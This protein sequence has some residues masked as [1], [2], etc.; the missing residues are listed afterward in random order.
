MSRAIL[1]ALLL[2]AALGATPSHAAKDPSP[3][4][5]RKLGMAYY[6]GEGVPTDYAKA[7]KHLARAVDLGDKEA[8]L[9]LGKM[10]EY[11]FGV[12]VDQRQAARWYL[13]GAELNDPR[14]QFEASIFLYKGW[15]ISQDRVQAA[16]WWTLAI[17]HDERYS[18]IIR[19]TIE[20]VEEDLNPEVLAEGRR[21]AAAW[22]PGRR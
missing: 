1:S 9:L 15:G 10:Y 20:Q 8:A 16:K 21:L 14:C 5:L 12:P 22:K 3:E 7:V 4:A 18:K 13:A 17:G 19:P 2:A 6:R 11:G